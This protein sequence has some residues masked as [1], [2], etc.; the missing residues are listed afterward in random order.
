MRHEKLPEQLTKYLPDSELELLWWNPSRR[1][2]GLRLQKE[3]GPEAGVLRFG[4]VSHINLPPR[5]TIAG[6][7]CGGLAELPGDYLAKYRPG[8]KALDPDECAFIIRGSWGDEWFV[9]ACSIDYQ[10]ET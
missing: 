3:I 10:I 7:S 2:L 1:E 6:I 9:V 4:G 5:L 8:D